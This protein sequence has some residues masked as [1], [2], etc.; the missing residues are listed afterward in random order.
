MEADTAIGLALVTAY[1]LAFVG[2]ACLGISISR[3]DD[4]D[5]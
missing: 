5:G 2:L 3:D 4:E 1:V